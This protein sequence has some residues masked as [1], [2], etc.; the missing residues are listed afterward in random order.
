MRPRSTF[1]GT[2]PDRGVSEVIG[3]IL[4]FGLLIALLAMVQTQVVPNAN[5]DIEATHAA[6]VQGDMADL[7]SSISRSA[8]LG[9]TESTTVRTG[10]TY[11]PRLVLY[12]PP[13]V[14]GT[15]TTGE[16]GQ[17]DLGGFTAVNEDTQDFLA[18]GTT[19]DTHTVSYRVEYNRY[20]NAPTTRYEHSVLV[21]D[22][23]DRAT[24]ESAGS[25]V[26]GNR[27]S[28]TLLRGGLQASQV[29][30]ASVST[31]PVS[32][33]PRTVNVEAVGTQ[34]TITV[35]TGIDEETWVTE[36]LAGQFDSNALPGRDP[37]V[38]DD[39]DDVPAGDGDGT[40]ERFLVGC[41]YT[42]N[43]DA[44]N[45]LTLTF[46]QG[47]EYELRTAKVGFSSVSDT[48]DPAYVAEVTPPDSNTAVVE[49]RDRF[50]NP[51]QRSVALTVETRT[52]TRTV[53]TGPDGRADVGALSAERAV[54]LQG[55][56]GSNCDTVPTCANA[57]P[58]AGSAASAVRVNAVSQPNGPVGDQI[59][60][61]FDNTGQDETEITEVQLGYVTQRT[62]QELTLTG[63]G[64]L[65]G[66]PSTTL[67]DDG[68]DSIVSITDESTGTTYD[69]PSG[70]S[71]SPPGAR[72]N[73]APVEFTD[74]SGA[75]PTLPSSGGGTGTR[76][77][78]FTLN[79]AA[80]TEDRDS[81]DLSITVYYADG[82]SATY[83][84]TLF[85]Q[86]GQSGQDSGS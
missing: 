50:N 15:L 82:S 83:S 48:P 18:G 35:P 85:D 66:D 74:D 42:E 41:S 69:P 53:V 80:S 59:A 27:I 55:T 14:Q 75:L 64:T 33:P 37:S 79:E 49:V 4:V 38:C 86:D 34:P 22:Y 32:S 46:E 71:G 60:F 78:V 16:T 58:V 17:V 20:E 51:V 25:L 2:D 67:V 31:Y 57:G 68:P 10:M 13:P 61:T 36:L 28:L 73:L 3:S 52:G 9:S 7:Q 29:G 26:R 39:L 76:T 12:N 65:E 63:G 45:E 47:A 24:V 70:Q 56:S 84:R 81:V 43:P 8:A 77:M 1:D 6:D 19:Y 54:F 40:D 11:P 30:P 21:N 72:E 23:G 62:E 44:P 5:E